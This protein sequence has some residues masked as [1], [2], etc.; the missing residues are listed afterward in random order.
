VLSPPSRVIRESHSSCGG[1][2]SYAFHSIGLVSS[3][4]AES[5]IYI[6]NFQNDTLWET[7]KKQWKDPPFL[8][9]KSTISMVIF[10]SYVSLPEGRHILVGVH[11]SSN[12]WRPRYCTLLLIY[13]LFH[14]KSVRL[15]PNRGGK[16]VF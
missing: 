15:R 11:Q 16:Q 2:S 7:Y 4:G 6:P 13:V 5:I 14:P 12:L 10:N 9:G 1:C 3:L 8:M